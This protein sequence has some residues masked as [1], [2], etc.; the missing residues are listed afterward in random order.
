VFEKRHKGDYEDLPSS[1]RAE[2][3]GWLTEAKEFI[4]RVSAA[5]R[6]T[7]GSDVE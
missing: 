1:E 3:Q 7:V 4:D 2:L 5:L 6:E